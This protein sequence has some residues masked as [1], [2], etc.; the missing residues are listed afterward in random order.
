MIPAAVAA[1]TSGHAGGTAREP[2]RRGLRDLPGVPDPE[3]IGAG[4]YRGQ[5]AGEPGRRLSQPEPI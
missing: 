1:G 3:R 2:G 5:P 4:L